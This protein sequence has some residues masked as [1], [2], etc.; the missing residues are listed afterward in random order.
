MARGHAVR[1]AALAA[2]A[3][4]LTPVASA[5]AQTFDV[6]EITPTPP[7]TALG[8]DDINASG[9]VVGSLEH[10]YLGE[11]SA[12]VWDPSSGLQ[13]LGEFDG[14]ATVGAAI[15]DRGVVTGAAGG[16]HVYFP[17]TAF[18]WT[19]A[20]GF[21]SLGLGTPSGINDAGQTIGYWPGPGWIVWDAS[22]SV[23]PSVGQIYGSPQAINDSGQI[24]GYAPGAQAAQ[25]WSQETGLGELPPFVGGYGATAYDINDL[26]VATGSADATY[27]TKRNTGCGVRANS[28]C[29]VVWRAGR[30]TAVG[31]NTSIGYGINNNADVVGT[32]LAGPSYTPHA[33]LSRNGVF[34][35]LNQL[36]PTSTPILK[37]AR[38]INDSG[39]I[40]AN[41]EGGRA[42]VLIPR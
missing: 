13:A 35:D 7:F 33:F 28:G 2:L 39:W 27:N 19:A 31:P 12:F 11:H 34:S 22:G 38:A 26:G 21:Q 23:Q 9:Q 37:E 15:N 41:S 18:R 32:F 10:T 29:A 1:L 5:G 3:C 25:I 30:P 8:A 36:V 17:P 20:G 4:A 16:S 40:V 42:F 24:V 14:E 6:R